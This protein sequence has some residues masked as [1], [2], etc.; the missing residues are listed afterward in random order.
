MAENP[1][2]GTPRAW[3]S[4]AAESTAV[5]SYAAD[6]YTAESEA[7]DPQTGDAE[8]MEQITKDTINA[9]IRGLTVVLCA[10]AEQD[11]NPWCL[12][13]S[14]DEGKN[15][16]L[17]ASDDDPEC[18]ILRRTAQILPRLPEEVVAVGLSDLK[19]SEDKGAYRL[20]ARNSIR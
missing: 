7:A 11:C 13:S 9:E 16:E 18:E 19:L 17:A 12:N 2:A 5:E 10:G 4:H 20:Y 14:I 3:E 6:P 1:Q 8:A 15:M